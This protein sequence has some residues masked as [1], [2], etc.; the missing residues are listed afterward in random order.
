MWGRGSSGGSM[1]LYD[2]IVSRRTIREFKDRP[3]SLELL[4]NFVNAGRLA[5]QTANRQPLEFVIVDDPNICE[6]MF[7]L[8]KF[9]GSIEWEPEAAKQPRAYI[10]IVVNKTIQKPAWAPFDVALASENISLA[11]WEEG[12]GSCLLGAFSKDKVTELLNIP[13]NYDLALLV[14][15]GYPA[16]KAQIEEMEGN[17]VEYWR[18]E[19]G[20]FHVPKRPLKKLIH[21]NRF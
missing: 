20:T 1:K 11:A 5:P 8:V 16:H 12:V 14:A 18:D 13:E 10:A 7:S 17:K 3:V 4:E 19:D 2:L 9:A 6:K 21:H 15:L